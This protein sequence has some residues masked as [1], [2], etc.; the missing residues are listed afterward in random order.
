MSFWQTM[1]SLPWRF[2]RRL[3]EAARNVTHWLVP[4]CTAAARCL[5][6]CI[7]VGCWWLGN[8]IARAWEWAGANK[9]Q[10]TLLFAIIAGIYVLIEYRRNE[11]DASIKRTMEFQARY[12]QSEILAARLK[13]DT[14][15]LDPE[16]KKHLAAATGTAP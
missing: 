16:S 11:N 8:G 5:R 13:L 4:S 1:A 7:V 15:W 3:I 14:F 2:G 6:S 10:V 9:E 12:T